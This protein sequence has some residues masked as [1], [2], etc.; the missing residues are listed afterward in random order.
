MKSGSNGTQT[1]PVSVSSD[2]LR[3][4]DAVA[5]AMTN[6]YGSPDE[7]WTQ[8]AVLR[9][10]LG[11]G[12]EQMEAR[13]LRD[14]ELG[15]A[16]TVLRTA[17]QHLVHTVLE[18]LRSEIEAGDFG[19]LGDC[20]TVDA[21][22]YEVHPGIN[23]LELRLKELGVCQKWERAILAASQYANDELDCDDGTGTWIARY[24]LARDMRDACRAE[25]RSTRGLAQTP[26]T[27]RTGC[28]AGPASNVVELFPRTLE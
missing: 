14:D 20:Y 4:A 13:H 28:R 6:F 11:R 15:H 2:M 8:G 24:C 27:A 12:V 3:T 23:L 10:A 18:Q 22:G 21:E 17:Y 9:D 16:M 5:V 26:T 25:Q 7:P 19:D 1:I